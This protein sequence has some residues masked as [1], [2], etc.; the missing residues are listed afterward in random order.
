M[1]LTY[2]RHSDVFWGCGRMIVITINKLRY[3]FIYVG[4]FIQLNLSHLIVTNKIPLKKKNKKCYKITFVR[5]FRLKPT[6]LTV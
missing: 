1:E 5:N 6:N 3:K 2:P 4:P